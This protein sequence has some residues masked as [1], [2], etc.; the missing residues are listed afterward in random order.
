[1]PTIFDHFQN[2]T[3]TNDQH[4]A[5]EKITEFLNSDAKI[6][7]LKGYAGS[8]KTTLLKGL[9]RY[10][11]EE[12]KRCQV[13]A[14]TGRA[15]KILRKKVGQGA[16]IHKSIYA[17]EDIILGEDNCYFLA[18]L[19]SLMG[20]EGYIF[21]IDEAS[22]VSNMENKNENLKF[23]TDILLEDLITYTRVRE[24]NNKVIF[25]GD[26]AQ[27]PPVGEAISQALN[28][29]F[30]ENMGLKPIQAEM[31]KVVRQDNNLILENATK[32]RALLAQEKRT[33]LRFDY[34]HTFVK[35]GIEEIA[36]KYVNMYPIP[37]LSQSVIIAQSNTQCLHYNQNIRSKIFP[38]SPNVVPGDILLI[39]QN[40]YNKQVELFNGDMV[41]VLEVE[42]KLTVRSN[43]PVFE[44]G[45]KKTITL[46]FRKV[47]V[48]PE[49]SDIIIECYII[50]TLLNSKE[51]ALTPI[52]LKALYIDFKIR[53]TE[54][55]RNL[56]KVGSREFKELLKTDPFFNALR[57]KYGYAIT[58]H[59]AQGGEWDTV[60]VDYSGRVGLNNDAL[61]WSY[62]ATT[63]AVN[64][65]YAANAPHITCFSSFQIG[66]IGAVAKMPKETISI[67]NIPLSPFHTEG[68]HRAK[69]LKYWEIVANLETTPYKV[70]RVES[71]GDYQERYIISNGGEID[72]FDVFHTGAGVFKDFKPLHCNATAWQVEVLILLNKPNTDITFDIDYAPSTP[73][74]EKLYRL[75][76]SACEDAEVTIT[77]IEERSKDYYVLYYLKTDNGKGAY[78]Q[79]Y[80]NNKEQLTRAIPKS[81][82]GVN[83]QKL[84]LL[85]QK[86]KEYVL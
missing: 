16:T 42:D 10:L 23:G 35:L 51:R 73:L 65:C 83:D 39:N 28:P 40:N 68:Q 49:E 52:E 58:C 1:M 67:E 60:F 13:M 54:K 69:S 6:F 72:A 56:Y 22:M 25:V 20:E 79:F 61:R 27:L 43:I 30:F 44:E 80:F 53:F 70:E 31:T 7:I 50:D 48:I 34:D 63:R 82:N 62:T 17:L 36:D 3:L 8:G 84:Q 74:F 11:N 57:V 81:M 15:A 45:I 19:R 24:A 5:L 9:V 55:Y 75:M 85:I 86:L 46:A 2:L 14:P 37:H 33:E 59:K 38:N 66:Q 41:K 32:I 71:K 26:P 18:P 47:K 64:K 76:Q 12:K 77:N 29:T 4:N 21:I 78:I